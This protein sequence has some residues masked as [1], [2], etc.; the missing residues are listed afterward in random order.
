MEKFED[1][2]ILSEILIEVFVEP[3]LIQALEL[4]T[5]QFLRSQ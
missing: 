4:L 3:F 5:R 2:G 1:L